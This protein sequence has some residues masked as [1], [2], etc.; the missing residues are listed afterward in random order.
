VPDQPD[1]ATPLPIRRLIPSALVQG[2]RTP[3]DP[4]V[5]RQAWPLDGLDEP[6]RAARRRTTEALKRWGL[7][8]L[9]DDAAIVVSE[10]VTNAYRHGRPPVELALS[11]NPATRPLSLLV[12]VSDGDPTL[13]MP[14]NPCEQGG[15]GLTVLHGHADLTVTVRPDGKTVHA[16]L[17]MEADSPYRR[18]M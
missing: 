2:R 8:A 12:D 9:I 5:L 14:R 17:T 1:N 13:P 18:P 11:L 3:R 10:L 6:V 15:F 16:R 7:P 4:G